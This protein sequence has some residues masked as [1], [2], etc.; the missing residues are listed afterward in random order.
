MYRFRTKRLE[1]KN[2]LKGLDNTLLVLKESI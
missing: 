2:L 1:K